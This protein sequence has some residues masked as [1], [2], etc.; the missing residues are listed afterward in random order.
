MGVSRRWTALG[1]A[2]LIAGAGIAR[3]AGREN[4]AG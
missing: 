2:A 3:V 1:A 4:R